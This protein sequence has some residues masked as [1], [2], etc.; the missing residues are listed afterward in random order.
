MKLREYTKEDL[1]WILP[2]EKIAWTSSTTPA[3][4]VGDRS[5]EE[6]LERNAFDEV[7][8]AEVNGK[9]VGI[10]GYRQY[11]PFPAGDHIRALDITVKPEFRRQGYGLEMLE[12]IK[13]HAEEDGIKKLT[14]RVLSTNPGALALYKKA[15]FKVEGHL[16]KEFFIDGQYVDDTALFYWVK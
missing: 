5:A 2:L 15:G 10:I 7:L 9:P 1:S 11:Y 6:F 3:P 4:H 14:L 13:K 16:E 12:L 8:V